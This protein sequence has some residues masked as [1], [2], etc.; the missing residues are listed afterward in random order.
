MPGFP[1]LHTERLVL[2]GPKVKDLKPVFAVHTDP[3][4]MRFYG[5]I[6]YD[7]M[8]KARGGTGNG[9]CARVIYIRVGIV[10]FSE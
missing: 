8:D 6:P 3:D 4:V 5:I 9:G 10:N 7:S 2:R 1:E